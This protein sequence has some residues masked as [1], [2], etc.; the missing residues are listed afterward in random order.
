MNDALREPCDCAPNTVCHCKYKPV[1]KTKSKGVPDD[2][3]Q[4]DKKLEAKESPCTCAPKT[5]CSCKK[6]P[7]KKKQQAGD[8][9]PEDEADAKCRYTN[10]TKDPCHKCD[11]DF[12][13]RKAPEEN[14]VKKNFNFKIDNL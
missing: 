9:L 6:K 4:D 12:K 8:Q 1:K 7:K 10:P 13:K 3:N 14:M 11:P 2:T 5:V